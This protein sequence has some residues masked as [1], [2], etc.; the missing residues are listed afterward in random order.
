MQEKQTSTKDSIVYLGHQYDHNTI[1]FQ[2]TDYEKEIPEN[3]VYLKIE[4]LKIM[5][6]LTDDLRFTVTNILTERAGYMKAQLYEVKSDGSFVK[7]S[8][9]FEL[10]VAKSVDEGEIKEVTDTQLNLIYAQM[11]ELYIDLLEKKDNGFFN[12]RNGESAYEIAVKYGFEGTEEE[13][14]NLRDKD[15]Q[16]INKKIETIEKDIKKLNEFING[17]TFFIE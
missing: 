11:H 4:E 10:F 14:N 6:P 1:T 17:K 16:D 7:G 8:D 9:I 5:Y 3:A 2:F 13:W 15:I 12:G